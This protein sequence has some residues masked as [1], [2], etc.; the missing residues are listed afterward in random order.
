LHDGTRLNVSSFVL[1]QIVSTPSPPSTASDYSIPLKDVVAIAISAASFCFAVAAFLR[2]TFEQRRRLLLDQIMTEMTALEELCVDIVKQVE[3]ILTRCTHSG[4][5]PHDSFVST[6]HD[7]RKAES[8]LDNLELILPK[9]KEDIHRHYVDWH[10]ALT[11]DRFPVLQAQHCYTISDERF[12]RVATGQSLWR[13]YLFTLR[14]R[15]LR[16]EIKFWRK[17]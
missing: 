13:R 15:C 3:S 4:L 2:T 6:Q 9:Q 17:K 14:V 8:R 7:F 11:S 16:N 10:R 1:A 12:I 5:N